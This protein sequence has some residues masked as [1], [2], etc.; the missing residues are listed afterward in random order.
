MSCASQSSEV[1]DSEDDIFDMAD[2]DTDEA[3]KPKAKGRLT[4][5]AKGVKGGGRAAAKPKSP[6]KAKVMADDCCRVVCPR[7]STACLFFVV[8]V[9]LGRRCYLIAGG[10]AIGMCV[11]CCCCCV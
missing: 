8:S 6:P 11:C 1:A 7:L 9:P 10:G 5:G 2:S 4:K 3:A